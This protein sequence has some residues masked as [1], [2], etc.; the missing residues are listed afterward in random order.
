MV[1]LQVQG[2]GHFCGG[3]ILN[4]RWILTAAHCLH[5][6]LNSLVEE[7]SDVQLVMGTIDSDRHDIHKPNATY[8][9]EKLLLSKC[10]MVDSDNFGTI[11]LPPKDAKP[12]NDAVIMADW[13]YPDPDVAKMAVMLRRV[14]TKIVSEDLCQMYD[15]FRNVGLHGKVSGKRFC[16]MN[17]GSI[18]CRGDSGSPLIQV[19]N[20]KTIG[21]IDWI[22]NAIKEYDN[23]ST[24]DKHIYIP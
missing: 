13:D 16:V 24:S 14:D 17:D 19:V 9:G 23:S 7:A 18:G 8:K 3:S 21:Y 6:E 5:P 2:F 15:Y 10:F 11:C 1:S 20:G 4:N 22:T 12:V